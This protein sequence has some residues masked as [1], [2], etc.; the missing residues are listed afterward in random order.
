MR[1][2]TTSEGAAIN[3]TGAKVIPGQY[4]WTWDSAADLPDGFECDAISVNVDVL[5]EGAF[6]YFVRFNGN[7][8]EGTMTDEMFIYGVEKALPSNAFKRGGYAFAGWSTSPDGEKAYDD[9]ENILNLSTKGGMVI[10][11]YA[12]WKKERDKVQLWAGGPYW[13]TTNIGAEKPEEYGYYFWWGDTVGYKRENDK[14]VA[15]DGS[16]VNFSFTGGNTPTYNK[17]ITTLQSD[18]WIMAKGGTNVL[19]PEHDAVQKKWGNGW[20]MPT[21]LEF[22]YLKRYCDRTMVTTNGVNGYI[23]RGRGDYASNSIFIPCSGCGNGISLG[24]VSSDG[25]LWAYDPEPGDYYAWDF[26]VN[27]SC[28]W[29][30]RDD[31]FYG[32]PIRPVQS[33]TK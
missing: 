8:A 19:V 13:A 27:S 4:R 25:W 15:S 32:M 20:R 5:G 14:W 21:S 3:P 31:R 17:S 33:P 10:N 23:I 6:A 22:D 18:G 29:A 7:G 1:T 2:V 30:R 28:F 9:K 12:V 11:L 26:N 24:G 16:I